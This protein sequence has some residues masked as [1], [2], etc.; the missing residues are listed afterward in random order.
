MLHEIGR[1][2][3][4]TQDEDFFRRELC[5]AGYCLAWLD[6]RAD[7]TA[8]Y[9]RRFLSHPQ[10]RTEN[11]R[12]GNGRTRASRLHPFLATQPFNTPTGGMAGMISIARLNRPPCSSLAARFSPVASR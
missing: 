12:M 11:K 1:V 6:V 3:F 4:F 5:H 7:D 2:T 8:L 9:V 10:F